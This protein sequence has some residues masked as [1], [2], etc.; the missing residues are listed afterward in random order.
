LSKKQPLDAIAA[1]ENLNENG[2]FFKARAI[3]QFTVNREHILKPL[4]SILG[5]VERK[6]TQPMLVNV[7]LAVKNQTLILTATD[8]EIELI[9]QIALGDQSTPEPGEIA[10]PARKFSDICRSLPENALV[11]FKVDT[12]ESRVTVT[13]GKSRFLLSS[14]DAKDFP[15]IESHLGD[16][17]ITLLQGELN[18][19]L[20]KAQFAMAQQDVR[21]FLNGML[22]EVSHDLF[23]VVATDGHRLAMSSLEKHF[24]HAPDKQFIVPRKAIIELVRLIGTED[25]Q[26]I[27][28][29]FGENH[30]RFE[31][32]DYTFTSKLLEGKYPDYSRVIPPQGKNIL[33]TQRELL[34][35]ALT[36]ASI[37]CNDQFRGVRIQLKPGSLHVTANNPEHEEASDEIEVHYNGKNLQMGFN[38][39]YLLDAIQAGTGLDIEIAIEDAHSSALLLNPDDPHTL[40]V[41]MP[42]RL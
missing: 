25:T 3:M 17:H 33:K 1:K 11:S 37:L 24:D 36:R 41:V 19:L 22:F 40:F 38:A 15:Q 9:A 39:A 35:N 5:V 10:V 18:N 2:R 29:T 28:I 20:R 13:S 12:H 4:Q 32:S 31:M 8:L 42:I 21:Y 27:K 34:K 14:M 6:H 23:R 30:I 16:H 26:P 7:K